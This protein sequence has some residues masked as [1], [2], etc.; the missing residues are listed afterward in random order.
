MGGTLDI[1]AKLAIL[2]GAAKYDASCASSGS[3]ER[4]ASGG[5]KAGGD[6]S[7]GV[8]HP[9]G[10]CHSWTEDG[11]C[12]SLLKVLFS[13]RCRF[14]CAYCVNRASADT[15]RSSFTVAELVELTCQFYRRNYIEGLFLSS[16]I[17]ADPDIVMGKLIETARTLRSQAG[18]GGYIHLKIIPGAG[19]K[20]IREAG[21][22]A[23]RLSANIELPTEKSLNLL[24]P[25]KSG[26]VIFGAMGNFTGLSREFE[27]DRRRV[28]FFPQGRAAAP[29]FAPAGQSTQLIVGASAEDDRQIIGLSSSLYRKFSLRRV[30]YSAFIPVGPGRGGIADPRL[31]EFPGPPIVGG[32][33]RPPLDLRVREHRL[34]QADWL[35]RFYHFRASEIL[36]E[37]QPFLDSHIDPKTAWALKHLDFFPVEINRADY[38]TLLRVPGIGA[39]TARRIIETR[40]SG[41]LSFDKLRRLGAVMKRARYFTSCSGGLLDRPDDPRRIRRLLS[42]ADGAGLQLPLFDF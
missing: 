2:G 39:K 7:F 12:V 14:D 23:D 31:P 27:E 15:P 36:D 18:Y 16:G 13:N 4:G 28:K 32:P 19:E 33:D 9:A 25:Q 35:L 8:S 11:R 26:K 42:D 20:P 24:A 6:D 41:G 34:Y 22:W 21:R 3:G 1:E 17:F 29:V 5:S 40:R 30:Y 38:E 37:S 10:I